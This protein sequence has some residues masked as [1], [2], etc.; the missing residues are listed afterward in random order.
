MV[1]TF[2][3]YFSH[4]PACDV[5]DIEAIAGAA[6]VGVGLNADARA[7]A[8]VAVAWIGGGSPVVG[9]AFAAIVEVVGIDLAG[10]GR[11]CQAR[12]GRAQCRCRP[13]G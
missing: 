3:V 1:C 4:S 7:R 12:E 8:V 6:V 9:D 13:P 5:A 11:G 2:A 10:N